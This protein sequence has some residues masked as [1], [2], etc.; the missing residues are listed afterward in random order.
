M[1]FKELFINENSYHGRQLDNG[2][3]KGNLNGQI[4][5]RL[6]EEH[7]KDETTLA[8]YDRDDDGYCKWGVVDLDEKN[9]EMI[10][11][12][13]SACINNLGIEEKALLP[14]FTGNRGYHLFIFFKESIRVSLAKK[15]LN[16]IKKKAG[17]E[18]DFDFKNVEIYPNGSRH[19][20]RL[21]GL[22]RKSGKR[23]EYLDLDLKPLGID[24]RDTD[25]LNILGLTEEEVQGLCDNTIS[26]KDDTYEK[27]S[28]SQYNPNAE[29]CNALKNIIKVI[30]K[31]EKL[32]GANGH[33][34]RVFLGQLAVN[35]PEGKRWIHELFSNLSDYKPVKT[36]N[37]LD[38]LDGYCP[39]LCKSFA[40]L[41][42]CQGNCSSIGDNKSPIKFFVKV[43][44]KPDKGL[45][46]IMEFIKR[47]FNILLSP[48]AFVVLSEMCR[49]YDP[50][51][52]N[53]QIT[54]IEGLKSKTGINSNGTIYKVLDELTCSKIITTKREKI[55]SKGFKTEQLIFLFNPIEQ[56]I[57]TQQIDLSEQKEIKNWRKRAKEKFKRKKAKKEALS[58]FN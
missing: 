57:D 4:T 42:W 3:Y 44:N 21:P 56:W 45:N 25:R 9:D 20:V 52:R 37:M 11:A 2:K 19:L 15:L 48:T 50:F 27:V 43:S 16:L 28:Y 7:F 22:H 30:I 34:T 18:S 32:G 58:E 55:R 29:R 36:Q 5:Q 8:T 49:Y 53:I 33:N 40:R 54:S 38:S 47:G 12:L 31:E 17:E 35:L 1:D 10:K 46:I 23:S 51:T 13:I 26:L 6:L 39:P 41:G 14:V 24:I